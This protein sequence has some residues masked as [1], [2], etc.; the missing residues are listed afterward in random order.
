MSRLAGRLGLGQRDY[1]LGDFRPQRRDAGG[2]PK[3]PSF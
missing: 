3:R 1:P 2:V